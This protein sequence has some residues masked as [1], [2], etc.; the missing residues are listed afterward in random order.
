MKRKTM[1]VAGV[2]VVVAVVAVLLVSY[3]T[4]PYSGYERAYDKLFKTGS[5]ELNLTADVKLDSKDIKA[6]GNMKTQNANGLVKFIYKLNANNQDITMFSDGTNVY[7][8]AEGQKTMMKAGSKP[9]QGERAKFDMA[10]FENQFATMIEAGKLKDIQLLEKVTENLATKVNT[11]KTADG[12]RYEIILSD[13]LATKVFQSLVN[14]QVDKN[15]GAATDKPKFTLNSFKYYATEN[16]G[17]YLSGINYLADVVAVMPASLTGESADK[18]IKMNI[19]IKMEVVNPGQAVAVTLPD[20][21][22]YVEQK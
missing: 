17:G 8:E 20:T 12:K 19:D 1:L 6:T 14:E 9:A 2:V 22:G 4:N 7:K 18:T 13:T 21:A 16:A 3:L 15:M 10:M 11:E 5:M